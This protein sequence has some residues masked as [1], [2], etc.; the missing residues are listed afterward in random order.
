MPAMSKRPKTVLQLVEPPNKKDMGRHYPGGVGQN[1]Y[2]VDYREYHEGPAHTGGSMPP[3]SS[4][5]P[6]TTGAP[7]TTS[8]DSGLVEQLET[9]KLNPE[10]EK[11]KKS[12]SPA[13]LDLGEK[14]WSEQMA[15]DTPISSPTDPHG[16]DPPLFVDKS[17]DSKEE[18]KGGNTES[19]NE[20]AK[21]GSEEPK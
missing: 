18:T 16:P 19:S 13:P 15:D 4:H 12:P 17:N 10:P 11:T 6:T 7:V 3:S 21:A 2:E 5:I 14:S 9:M 8:A 1:P 20:Q